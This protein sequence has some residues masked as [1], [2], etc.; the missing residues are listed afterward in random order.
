LELSISLLSEALQSVTFS[1]LFMRVTQSFYKGAVWE[2]KCWVGIW[3]GHRQPGVCKHYLVKYFRKDQIWNC[4]RGCEEP[5][6]G[7]QENGF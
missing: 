3:Q 2:T 6:K 4:V 7:H 5:L 1:V